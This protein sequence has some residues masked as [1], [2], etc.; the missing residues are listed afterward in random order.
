MSASRKLLQPSDNSRD[1]HKPAP[2]PT[3]DFS[4]GVLKDNAEIPDGALA[5]AENV[6]VYPTE[7]IG[8]TGS[9]LHTLTQI[10]AMPDRTGYSATKSINTITTT[11]DVF[12]EDDVTNFFVWPG[13]PNQHDEII[14]YI[15]PTQVKVAYK[16]DFDDIVTGCYL[17][18]RNDFFGFHHQ[19]KIWIQQFYRQFYYSNI[20][21]DS[22]TEVV[23]ISRDLP[24]NNIGGKAEFDDY[25]EL[26]FN[27]NGIFKLDLEQNWAYK[28]NIPVPDIPIAPQEQIGGDDDTA[29][30]Y[31]YSAARLAGQQ[32]IRNRLDPIRIESETGTNTEDIVTNQAGLDKVWHTGMISESNPII[33]GPLWVPKVPNTSPQEYQWHLTHFPIYRTLEIEGTY[34][35]LGEANVTSRADFNNPDRFVWV[36]DLRICGAFY[37]RKQ[38]GLIIAEVGEFE[39]ADVG[40]VVEWENGDRDEITEYIEPTIVRYAAGRY[41]YDLVL[42]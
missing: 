34:A 28:L 4:F 5:D 10:P 19:R 32:V 30:R 11:T 15:S 26:V 8:R 14:E 7:F 29:F 13:D 35:K 6:V 42:D 39:V 3:N 38:D 37:A 1:R 2:K 12:T 25:S 23:T 27:S 16:N 40:S 36:N 22:W 21:M 9:E 20:D 41:D 24:F 17:R 31:L 33:V 18:G